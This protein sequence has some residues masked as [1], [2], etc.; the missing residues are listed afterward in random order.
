MTKCH[1][2]PLS[3]FV[4]DP[5]AGPFP[6]EVVNAL[7]YT[8]SSMSFPRSLSLEMMDAIRRAAA[9]ESH[10]LHHLL[11]LWGPS[12]MPDDRRVLRLAVRDGYLN[13][14]FRGQCVAKVTAPR[15]ELTCDVHVKYALENAKAQRYARLRGN[16]L[17]YA[18]SD[19]EAPKKRA[20]DQEGVKLPSV[21][22]DRSI[23]Y[24][25][26]DMLQSWIVRAENWETKEKAF[27]D[28]VIKSNP[29][30]I[31]VE[32]GI[33]GTGRRIDMVS[34]AHRGAGLKLA[35][36]EVKHCKDRV[37]ARDGDSKVV[38][39]MG[40]YR[41]FLMQNRSG[42]GG[43]YS[44]SSQNLVELAKLA[45]VEEHLSPLI[46]RAARENV[47]VDDLPILLVFGE[48]FELDAPE[49]RGH[50]AKLEKHATGFRVIETASET[51]D[52]GAVA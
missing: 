13:F 44:A 51:I 50:R 21:L 16:L 1:D 23:N 10:W 25:G 2:D 15:G 34:L 41:T 42:L 45:G 30:V 6:Y 22:R 4:P 39:Q 11:Q 17:T 43:A 32:L 7:R 29:S 27:I 48:K 31:D 9:D 24:G 12:G 33:P 36:W 35:F 46:S 18:A 8:R 26:P 20:P 3:D 28:R 40:D 19:L 37:R 14:Y 52:L 49:W 5:E 38:R 47:V